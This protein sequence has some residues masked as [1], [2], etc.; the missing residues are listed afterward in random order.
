[1]SAGVLQ[2]R[3]TRVRRFLAA[4]ARLADPADALG[5]AARQLLPESTGLSPA[6][7]SY[8]LEYSLER[9]PSGAELSRV[10]S[11]TSEAPTVHV[12]LSA[13]VFTAPVRAIALA[14]A[15][16]DRVY[17]RASRREP[18]MTELLLEA[19]GGQFQLVEELA[20]SAGDQLWAY[21]SD[22]A[23]TAVAQ[24]L[25]SGV[26][27]HAHGSGFGIAVVDEVA[28]GDVDRV[29]DR[30][31]QDCIAF[32]QRGCLS[33]R[34]VLVMAGFQTARTFAAALAR[35]L[36]GWQARIPLGR[37]S[38]DELA[39]IARFRESMV[40]AADDC[41]T[42][43]SGSVVVMR[44]SKVLALPP[45]GRNLLLV[46]DDDPLR[47]L[48]GLSGSVT[49]LGLACSEVISE[50][51]MRALPRAR[52]SGVGSMQRPVLDGPVDR[53]TSPRIIGDMTLG[54]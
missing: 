33:P 19:S 20:P 4:A 51:V 52:C 47:W 3:V 5:R 25:T 16:S 18:V 32:D 9:C 53:R 26:I 54:D 10:C 37:L 34:L 41:L 8:A 21:G 14:L 40:Y 23:L 35:A 39:S 13:N 44:Q 36:D 24:K 15:V 2:Q 7:V 17:V 6:G 50:Q 43:S 30:L 48:D 49:A 29:A 27:F 45:I 38:P 42:S 31:A 46:C 12:L 1:L 22:Q 11:Q 28:L